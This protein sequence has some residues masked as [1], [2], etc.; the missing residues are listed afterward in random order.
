MRQYH[1]HQHH[2]STRL[3]RSTR[4]LHPSS[5]R[6]RLLLLPSST[7]PRLLLPS[8]TRHRYTP[9]HLKHRRPRFPPRPPQDTTIR[10][11]HHPHKPASKEQKSGLFKQSLGNEDGSMTSNMKREICVAIDRP[12]PVGL[13]FNWF[14]G[15]PGGGRNN[16][17]VNVHVA[18]HPQQ[19]Q[20]APPHP[21]PYPYPYPSPYQHP[22]PPYY[23]P[24]PPEQAPPPPYYPPPPP[25]QAPPPAYYP[26]PPA[27]EQQ[28]QQP[29]RWERFKANF[30]RTPK[31]AADQEPAPPANLP[32]IP[33]DIVRPPA[34]NPAHAPPPTMPEPPP[35]WQ[36]P[37][38]ERDEAKLIE[39]KVQ[40]KETQE[41]LDDIKK[42]VEK[43]EHTQQVEQEE[44]QWL[45]EHFSV[46]RTP[47]GASAQ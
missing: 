14:A 39:T 25:E 10:P 18:P 35:V 43:I 8:S 23:Q 33:V 41:E 13:G 28:Q 44:L 40:T 17:V 37:P 6:H 30:K 26:P 31:P 20:Q 29:S 46:S 16:Q 15:W 27:Q 36:Q 1:H 24:P 5:T 22:P 7:R 47:A 3:P 11:R 9:R 4:L 21:Y 45:I 42:T 38:P 12:L 19:Q 2:P 34:F 32:V